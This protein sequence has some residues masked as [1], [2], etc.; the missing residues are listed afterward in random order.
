MKVKTN[1]KRVFTYTVES[2]FLEPR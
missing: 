2:L 1:A